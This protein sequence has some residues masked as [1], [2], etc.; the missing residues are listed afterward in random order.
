MTLKKRQ[1]HTS[2]RIA[3]VIIQSHT[4]QKTYV[5]SLHF[6]FSTYFYT[7]NEILRGIS[8]STLIKIFVYLRS[9]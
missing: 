9:T 7:L 5:K 1:R 2:R 8:I 4:S 6:K 3:Y